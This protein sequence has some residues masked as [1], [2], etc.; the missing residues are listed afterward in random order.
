MNESEVEAITKAVIGRFSFTLTS[1][2]LLRSDR[3]VILKG[4]L[5]AIR[6]GEFT[7]SSGAKSNF[8]VDARTVTMDPAVQPRLGAAIL[9]YARFVKATAIGGPATAAIPMSTA[10]GLVSAVSTDAAPIKKTF[11]VR[12]EPKKHGTLCQIEGLAPG[13]EDVVLLVDDVLTSGG[14]ILRAAKAVRETGAKIAGAL[15][16]LDRQEG[17]AEKLFAE[18]EI[19]MDAL[20]RKSELLPLKQALDEIAA[21]KGV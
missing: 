7:L 21:A 18:D 16:I 13:P 14:S 11:Y 9:E 15:V 5:G 2:R 3:L 1:D 12:P 17:G 10:A 6:L 19:V 8:Y 20:Y 4:L